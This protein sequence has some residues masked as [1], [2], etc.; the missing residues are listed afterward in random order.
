MGRRHRSARDRDRLR[1]LQERGRRAAGY[2][3]RAA[4]RAGV[5]DAPRTAELRDR[6]VEI[7]RQKPNPPEPDLPRCP[8]CLRSTGPP[9]AL[10]PFCGSRY[11]DRSARA[12]A[13]GLGIIGTAGIGL[14]L[15]LSGVSDTVAGIFGLIGILSLI[16]AAS[17]ASQARGRVGPAQ[18]RQTSCCGCSYVVAIV[19]VTSLGA[20]LWHQGGPALAAAAA[21]A[22]V[23]LSWLMRG[24]ER[25]AARLVR[26][27]E[28]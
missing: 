16:G 5:G 11:P 15:L 14:A 10:C 1:Q 17:M 19:A 13:A 22:W 23:P 2:G 12:T 4:V 8:G 6:A 21:P 20:L 28:R 25:L 24:W 27:S 7:E 18:P 3:A 9:G 26:G